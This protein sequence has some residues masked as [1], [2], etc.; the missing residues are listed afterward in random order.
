MDEELLEQAEMEVK[1]GARL[2]HAFDLLTWEN[3]VR[4]REESDRKFSKD[5]KE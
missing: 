2:A 1:R 3:H 4:E 5:S